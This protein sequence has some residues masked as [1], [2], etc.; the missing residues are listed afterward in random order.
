MGLKS[1]TVSRL[2]FFEIKVMKDEFM[3]VRSE[4]LLKKSEK[5]L[6]KSDLMIGQHFL[7]SLP[8]NPSGPGE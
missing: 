1:L 7:K 5:S 6:R 3:L 8:L 2:F 4:A